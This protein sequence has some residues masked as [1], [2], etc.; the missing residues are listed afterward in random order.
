MTTN[1]TSISNC[2]FT[3]ELT[4]AVNA[5]RE[6]SKNKPDV[7]QVVEALIQAEKTAKQQ[8]L[9]YPLT[10]LVGK[11]QLCFATGTRKVQNRGGIILGK[12]FYIPKFTPAYIS[13]TVSEDTQNQGEI[14][15]QIKLGLL[16]LKL[17]GLSQYIEKKNLLGFD[18]HQME[19]TLSKL[20]LYNGKLPGSK[21]QASNFYDASIGK[22]PFFAFFL[23]NEDFI[24]ARGRGGGL[25]LWVKDKN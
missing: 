1:F 18:F 25:A 13:F 21:T 11:W 23:V 6:N 24:A 19:I 8:R 12:G 3:T 16:S 20:R 17:S 5:Y 7:N 22:L 15:N 9:T 10:S 14:T 4:Q 2:N